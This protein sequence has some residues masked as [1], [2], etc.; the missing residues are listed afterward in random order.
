M[1]NY[2]EEKVRTIRTPD[3]R[4]VH[5]VFHDGFEGEADL[6]PLID[7]GPLYEQ[8]RTDESLRAVTVERGVPIWPGDF[9]LSPGTPRVWCEAGRFMDWEETDQWIERH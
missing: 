9:D 8:P 4:R 3:G 5:V 1:K 2:C 6:E 7:K